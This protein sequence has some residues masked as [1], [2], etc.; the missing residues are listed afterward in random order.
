MN[1]LAKAGG[2]EA[3]IFLLGSTIVASTVLK[4]AE[5]AFSAVKS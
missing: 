3:I 2:K 5:L 1:E 4:L